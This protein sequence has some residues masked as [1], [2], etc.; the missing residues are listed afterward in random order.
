M[1]EVVLR[2][3]SHHPQMKPLTKEFMLFSIQITWS[4]KVKY[5][6]SYQSHK[7]TPNRASPETKKGAALIKCQTSFAPVVPWADCHVHAGP[8]LPQTAMPPDS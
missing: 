7:N 8:A 2:D 5:V 4:L 1:H 3:P 6:F